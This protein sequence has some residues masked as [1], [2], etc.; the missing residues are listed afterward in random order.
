MPKMSKKRAINVK[1]KLKL[2]KGAKHKIRELE[3]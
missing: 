3:P 1:M 2:V